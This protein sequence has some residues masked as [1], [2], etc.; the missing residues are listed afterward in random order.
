AVTDLNE[1]DGLNYYQTNILGVENIVRISR[2]NSGIKRVIFAS[3]M[4]VNKVGYKPTDYFDY[5]PTTT[6]GHSKVMGEGIV[7]NNKENLTE[8]CIIRPTSIWGEWFSEPYRNFFDYI[9]SEKYFHP[10]KRTCTKTYG[11]VGNAVFQIY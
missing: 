11:Y 2:K 6:Y 8:F 1:K 10:G 3:S 5:N 7:F 4:L 9:L